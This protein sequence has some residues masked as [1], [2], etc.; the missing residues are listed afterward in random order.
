[1]TPPAAQSS[2]QA[3]LERILAS[4]TFHRASTLKTLL[5]YLAE[6]SFQGKASELDEF[7]IGVEACGKP[8]DYDPQS[9]PSV[10]VQIG[11]LRSKLAEYYASEGRHDPWVVTIPKGQ[12]ALEF[13]PASAA[14]QPVGPSQNGAVWA[15]RLA[16]VFGALSLLL[17]AAVL[18]IWIEPRW[19]IHRPLSRASLDPDRRILWRP[20]LEQ[21]RPV[22]VCLGVPLFVNLQREPGNGKPTSEIAVRNAFI[23]SLDSPVLHYWMNLLHAPVA[24]PF[25]HYVGIGEAMAAIS[26]TGFLLEAGIPFTIS[27]SHQLAWETVQGKTVIFIGP[28]KFN[29]QL[30][31]VDLGSSFV[32]EPEQIRNLHPLKGEP[33]VWTVDS[34]NRKIPAVVGR[35][36]NLGGGVVYLLASCNTFGSLAAARMV[37]EARLAQGLVARLRGTFGRV[38]EYF[39]ALIQAEV[40]NEFPVD[41]RIQAVRKV[42]LPAQSPGG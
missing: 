17:A 10:R 1:M 11:R 7:T 12:Y 28:P 35:Y 3:Q 41:L 29:P 24:E 20:L 36:P 15:R 27:R 25:R 26:V 21:H 13:V 42:D 9:D 23:N 14:P 16:W 19:S 6:K 8:G 32:V 18:L 34:A 33:A 2:L 37:S 4:R 5:R 40:D 31:A 38:P 30:S 39:E 22:I